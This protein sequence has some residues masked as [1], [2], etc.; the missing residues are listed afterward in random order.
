MKVVENL[1]H[2]NHFIVQFIVTRRRGKECVSI[3][4]EKIKNVDH[5]ET[6]YFNFL[7]TIRQYKSKPEEQVGKYSFFWLT[8]L[9]GKARI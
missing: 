9:R 4:D 3:G 8:S 6:K 2:S 5:L 1:M 7:R